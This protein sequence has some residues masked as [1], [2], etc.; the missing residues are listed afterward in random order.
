MEH[1]TLW[2]GING[3]ESMS[4]N[5]RGPGEELGSEVRLICTE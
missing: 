2:L 1:W 5:F 3:A 4:C